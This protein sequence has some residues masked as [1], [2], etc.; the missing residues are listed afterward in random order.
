[1]AWK[2]GHE[3]SLIF[4]QGE[5]MA[6][7]FTR[8]SFSSILTRLSN[9]V[10]LCQ[11]LSV[12]FLGTLSA[13]QRIT[14]LRLSTHNVSFMLS[15]QRLQFAISNLGEIIWPLAIIWKLK[16]IFEL[17]FKK[18]N[19]YVETSICLNHVTGKSSTWAQSSSIS[20]FI[21]DLLSVGRFQTFSITE[22]TNKRPRLRK[23]RLRK[24]KK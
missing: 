20:R 19:P 12:T 8:R 17:I 5:V 10:S 21:V 23:N 13:L 24:R 2:I 22:T 14:W 18:R 3:Y 15:F 4:C 9:V 11:P 7:E 16:Y 1:M 6:S